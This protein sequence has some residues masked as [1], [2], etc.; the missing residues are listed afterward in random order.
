M[1]ATR[2]WLFRKGLAAA[3]PRDDYSVSQITTSAGH[4]GSMIRLLFIAHFRTCGKLLRRTLTKSLTNLDLTKVYGE[5][6][7]SSRIMSAVASGMWSTQRKGVS[8]SLTSTN[9]DAI[10]AQLRRISSSLATTN[11]N[12]T[13]PRNVVNDQYGFVCAASSPDGETTGLIYELAVTATLSPPVNDVVVFNLVLARLLAPWIV[14]VEAWAQAQLTAPPPLLQ[15]APTL[16]INASG[17]WVGCIT[18]P[19][20]FV[21]HFRALRRTGQISPFA[22]LEHHRDFARI[23]VTY[24]EGIVCRPLLVAGAQAPPGLGPTAP[25]LARLLATGV[26]EY[27]SP[28]EQTTLCRI[29]VSLDTISPQSTH[30]ELIQSS[31]LGKLASSIA[32]AT[33]QQGPRL[34]YSTL[35]RKQIITGRTKRYR[36]ATETSQLW[37]THRPLVRTQLHELSRRAGRLGVT[38][39]PAESRRRH[40]PQKKHIGAGSL[41]DVR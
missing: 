16:Y 1:C 8:I 33:G 15:T 10:E 30:V 32:F 25:D 24:Q 39:T 2:L 28:A 29:A 9:H 5:H 21:A 36:G 18:D 40:H 41:H 11:G 23:Q 35:Q 13:A 20:K 14:P 19:H 6:R 34:T 31:F 26:L 3:T 38:G 7:L 37:N 17:D 22:F 27:V 12:H 4:L